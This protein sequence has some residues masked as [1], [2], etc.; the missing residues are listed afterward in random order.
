MRPSDTVIHFFFFF[1]LNKYISHPQESSLLSASLRHGSLNRANIPR[2][3]WA[4]LFGPRLFFRRSTKNPNYIRE[5][6]VRSIK[7]QLYSPNFFSRSTNTPNYVREANVSPIKNG[8]N[9]NVNPT[10]RRSLVVII[11]K[12]RS[13]VQISS[14]SHLNHRLICCGCFSPDHFLPRIGSA[15]GPVGR[16]G[17]RSRVSSPSRT[18]LCVIQIHTERK[19]QLECTCWSTV[20]LFYSAVIEIVMRYSITYFYEN[21]SLQFTSQLLLIT[22]TS[23]KGVGCTLPAS[24]QEIFEQTLVRQRQTIYPDAVY[25]LHSQ[26]K[27]LPSGKRY[28][29]PKCKLSRLK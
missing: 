8:L 5:A 3:C 11:S 29:I 13:G 7:N 1:F 23:S 18:S 27:L 17:I 20:L 12:H 26:Y 28:T 21:V 22:S 19:T 15:M 2:I 24:P 14:K 9:D 4:K 6:K 10:G 25:V 16:P